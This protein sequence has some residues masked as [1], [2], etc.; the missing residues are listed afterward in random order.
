MKEKPTT[1]LLEQEPEV[2]KRANSYEYQPQR[3]RG[4]NDVEGVPIV[5]RYKGPSIKAKQG[6]MTIWKDTLMYMVDDETRA[7]NME[8]YFAYCFRIRD[9][10][11]MV[12]IMDK[13]KKGIGKNWVTERSTEYTERKILD[14]TLNKKLSQEI[15][16]HG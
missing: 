4:L 14:L 3:P 16:I 11:Y 12:P 8:Q 6:D 1:W 13:S 7:H 2:F 5:N 10:D 9:L 15:L